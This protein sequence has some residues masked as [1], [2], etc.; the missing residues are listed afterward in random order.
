[1]ITFENYERKIGNILSVLGKYG[2]K[3]L[4]DAREICE[5]AGID[6]Y[7]TAKN[8]QPIC[9]EDVCYAYEELS[10]IS[11]N[12]T[13]AASFGNVHGVYKPGNVVLSPEILKNS[14]E[15]IQKKLGTAERPVNFVFHGGSGSEPEKIQEAIRYG[16]VKMNLDTDTQWAFW[17]GIRKYYNDKKDYLQGQLGN[18][19]GPD[20]PNKKFYD[21]RVWMREGEKS[22]VERIK[23]SYTCLHGEN[24]N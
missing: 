8:I 6:P 18:P 7:E 13:I 15:Y 10:K 9:F 11:P 12:F 22:M 14:Q 3:D 20:K 16:V 4:M 17:N 21:P 2:I 19:E 24:R 5:K 23:E 1:M